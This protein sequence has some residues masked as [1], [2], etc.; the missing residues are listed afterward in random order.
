MAVFIALDIALIVV[1]IV[2]AGIGAWWA[3]AGVAGF[4]ALLLLLNVLIGDGG[5]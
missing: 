5:F 2:L 3:A 1:L 4:M